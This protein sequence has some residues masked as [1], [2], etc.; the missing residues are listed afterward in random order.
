MNKKKEIDAIDVSDS[1]S[2]F[3]KQIITK[4]NKK[5]IFKNLQR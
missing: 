2:L 1:Y 5:S 4:Q 3:P